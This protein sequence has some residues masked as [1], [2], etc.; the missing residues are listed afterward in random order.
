M[1]RAQRKNW[2]KCGGR[3][4]TA[5]QDD[6]AAVGNSCGVSDGRASP[7]LT[8]EEILATLGKQGFTVDEMEHLRAQRPEQT[9]PVVA[10]PC[11]WRIPQAQH[12]CAAGSGCSFDARQVRV[13]KE[14]TRALPTTVFLKPPH[15]DWMTKNIKERH[16]FHLPTE[17]FETNLTLL[18]HLSEDSKWYLTITTG[19]SDAR[20]AL[21]GCTPRVHT[22]G[23]NVG[24]G[25]RISE[26][27]LV[28]LRKQ[29]GMKPALGEP[30]RRLWQPPMRKRSGTAGSSP[31]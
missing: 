1:T 23:P 2:K 26:K 19:L 17:M 4:R 10:K 7:E 5:Q 25:H 31:S 15:V 29:E 3:I 21:P 16:E 27:V 22:I 28:W 11:N 8:H 20:R 24:L 12:T 13:G 9:P 6:V 30:S 18:C 14:E